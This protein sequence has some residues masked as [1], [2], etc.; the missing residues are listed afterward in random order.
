MCIPSVVR[1]VLLLFTKNNMQNQILNLFKLRDQAVSS[2]DKVLFLSTQKKEI[3]KSESKGYLLN[4]KQVSSVLFCQ[5][6]NINKNL[7]IVLVKEE[8]FI[9]NQFSHQNYLIYKV[10]QKGDMFRIFD[11]LWS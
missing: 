6:D 4:D 2:N 8:Y 10:K 3:P 11:V 7:W 5:N 9:S 1:R